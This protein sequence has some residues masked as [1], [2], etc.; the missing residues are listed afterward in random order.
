MVTALHIFLATKIHWMCAVRCL[1]FFENA[2]SSS[3]F[4]WILHSLCHHCSDVADL[5]LFQ[6]VGFHAVAWQ[7]SLTCLCS[8]WVGH[9]SKNL[10]CFELSSSPG[11][12]TTDRYSFWWFF[13]GNWGPAVWRSLCYATC[14]SSCSRLDCD[15]E[16]VILAGNCLREFWRYSWRSH[17]S[18]AAAQSSHAWVET[19]KDDSHVLDAFFLP[20]SGVLPSNGKWN[21][22]TENFFVVCRHIH[23][24]CFWALPSNGKC[25]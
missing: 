5:H 2:I 11:L 4:G 20:R 24:S 7:R 13:L 17:L 15:M 12:R 8:V 3:I 6:Q 16:G 22:R 9:H 25:D 18:H 19:M 21:S 10:H 14:L 1:N 23:S